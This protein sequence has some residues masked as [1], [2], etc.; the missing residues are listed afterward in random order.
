MIVG[1]IL[2]MSAAAPLKVSP[3]GLYETHQME[4]A[5]ALEL[6]ADGHFRYALSYGAVD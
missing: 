4:V 5:A 2:L 1:A 3:V 6:K